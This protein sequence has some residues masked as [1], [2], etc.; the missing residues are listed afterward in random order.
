LI[1]KDSNFKD[2]KLRLVMFGFGDCMNICRNFSGWEIGV[3]EKISE[4]EIGVY[5]K[6]PLLDNHLLRPTI[7]SKQII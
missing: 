1:G 5:E 6:N 4:W 2:E 7:G 3:Y